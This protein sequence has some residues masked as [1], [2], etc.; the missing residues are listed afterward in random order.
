MSQKEK[1]KDK[2]KKMKMSENREIAKKRDAK[3]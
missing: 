3:K 2:Q 1:E